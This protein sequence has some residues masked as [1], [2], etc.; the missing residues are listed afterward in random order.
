MARFDAFLGGFGTSFSVNIASE[1]TINWIPERN[2]ISVNGQGTDVTDKNVRCTLVR[3]PGLKTFVT[4]PKTPVRGVFPGAYRLLAAAGDSFYEI[5][6]N[7][8]Y[9]DRSVPGFSG[10]SGIGPAGGS[11]G[12]DNLPVQC[13]FNGTQA[14][15]VSNEKVFC[16]NG[17][18]PVA[19]Q[20]SEPLNDL[21][22]DSADSTGTTLTTATG[23]AFDSTDVGRQVQITGGS[24]FNLI[25]QAIASVNSTGEAIG[26]SAWGT[27][28]STL[29]TGYEWLDQ[30]TA[31]Q[32]AFLDGYFFVTQPSTLAPSNTSSNS[33]YFSAINDGTHWNPLDFFKK[34]NYPD[35]VVAL[36]ADHEELYTFGDLESTQV[37]RDTG[38]ADNPFSA[39]Q[40]AIMHLGC[41]ARWSVVRLGNGVAWLGQDVRRGTRKAFSATGFNPVPVSTPGVEAQWA[42]YPIVS[43]AVGFTYADHGH[44]M[45]VICFP[46]GNA[47]WAYDLSTGWWTEWGLWN[48]SRGAWDRWPVWVHCVVALGGVGSPEKHYGGDW[49]T[50]QI[51]TISSDYK[52]DDG[53]Q[54]VRRRIAPHLTPENMRRFY[55]RFEIDCD[56]LGLQRVFWNRLGTGRDRIWSLDTIQTSETAGVQLNLSFSDDRLQTTQGPYSITLDPSVD[57][58]LVNAYL[59]WVDATWH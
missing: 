44:D 12:N 49:Q 15:I 54:V 16:D 31:G 13:F 30:V 48:N 4:L 21:V 35:N 18:G 7:G 9:T 14:L 8:T 23:N 2:A 53:R 28:G 58:S 38:N 10:S 55:S 36:F 33:V 42:K 37:W 1:R 22:V 34:S 19:C 56:V 17:N 20:F 25:T 6:A 43:D 47:T 52:T 51:Y 29:G 50:G 41:Q 24:G 45:W 40:G 57:V 26:A 46:S 32:G 5:F 27:P 3:R 11:I 59:N 39:D